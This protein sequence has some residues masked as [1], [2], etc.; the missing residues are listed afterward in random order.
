[1]KEYGLLFKGCA[2]EDE[3]RTF[4]GRIRDVTEFLAEF[5]AAFEIAPA[6][7][8]QP[9]RLA[10]HDACHLSHAQGIVDAPRQL[11]RS[12]P[13]LTL[14][15]IPEGELC[16]GSAGT[17]NVEQPD[18]ADQIGQRKAKNIL[19]T[20]ADAVAAGNIGCI[21]QIRTHL[22]RLHQPMPVLHTIEVLDRAYRHGDIASANS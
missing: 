14:V 10:Y 21:V 11:L 20:G 8:P 13:N 16:C 9:M 2:E 12:I 3:A 5:R 22:T 19:H 7:L 1:M 6:P 4:A 15:D 18:L 17:Y